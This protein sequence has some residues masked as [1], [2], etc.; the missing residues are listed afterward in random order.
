MS[1]IMETG[2]SVSKQEYKL[3]SVQK[4]ADR[5]RTCIINSERNSFEVCALLGA[6]S[7]CKEA[8]EAE[9]FKDIADF[10]KTLGIEKSTSYAFAAIGIHFVEQTTAG[11][12]KV[13]ECSLPTDG[14]RNWSTT[15]LQ[16]LAKLAKHEEVWGEYPS[17]SAYVTALIEDGQFNSSITT[18]ALKELVDN[19]IKPKQ[20]PTSDEE[21]PEEEQTAEPESEPETETVTVKDENG[22]EYQIPADILNKYLIVNQ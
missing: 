22:N 17:L 7:G 3:S 13:Y 5:I 15:Q 8:L 18:R 4:T 9:G 19:L 20:E 12:K 10:G 21:E 2:L 1:I 14:K 16:Y 11:K 6:L